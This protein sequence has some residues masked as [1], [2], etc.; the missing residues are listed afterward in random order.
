MAEKA[1]RDLNRLLTDHKESTTKRLE[2]ISS[3]LKIRKEADD[4]SEKDLS[5]WLQM[6]EK[7]KQQLLTPSNVMLQKVSNEIWLQPMVV[8]TASLNSPD[9]FDKASDNIKIL[10]NGFVAEHDG[11]TDHGEVRGFKT[12]ST[13]THK[14]NLKIE[15]M[16]NNNWMFWGIISQSTAM[17]H[18]S[19]SSTSANGWAKNPKQVYLNG[20]NNEGYNNYQADIVKNDIL[21]LTLNCDSQIIELEN[22]R[23]NQKNSIPIDLNRCPFPWQ[24]HINLYS[25]NDRIRILE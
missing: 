12:Y 5:E 20:V 9:K 24:L 2:E 3:Q 8:M 11:T 22:E 7:L 1:L 10:E 15:E 21:H 23:T 18:N 16:K 6:L 17:Q 4:Y 14:I 25:S 13:G 19:Y